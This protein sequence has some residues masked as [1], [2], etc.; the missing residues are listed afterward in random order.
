MV[1]GPQT[2]ILATPLLGYQFL[3]TVL[4][5]NACFELGLLSQ[6]SYAKFHYLCEIMKTAKMIRIGSAVVAPSRITFALFY[7]FTSLLFV[8]QAHSQA[9]ATDAETC[10]MTQK[11]HF[12]KRRAFCGSI[13]TKND[14]GVE[15]SRRLPVKGRSRQKEKLKY[16][17]TSRDRQSASTDYR[18][19]LVVRDWGRRTQQ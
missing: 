2:K 7:I 18:E 8:S 6:K 14:L 4:G 10:I 11:M 5:L 1:I 19:K 17:R 12:H 16:R 15:N 3:T 13:D 9:Y